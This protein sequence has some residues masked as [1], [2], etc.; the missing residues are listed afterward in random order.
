MMA[1]GSCCYEAVTRH[2]SS[3]QMIHNN[4]Q[5][6]RCFSHPRRDSSSSAV[7]PT[8]S[9]PFPPGLTRLGRS[10]S[11]AS[12]LNRIDHV[13]YCRCRL[14][15]STTAC[16]QGHDRVWSSPVLLMLSSSHHHL[17]RNCSG[18]TRCDSSSCFDD[19]DVV[20]VSVM[21]FWNSNAN[22][23]STTGRE[24]LGPRSW[25]DTTVACGFAA[26]SCRCID[27]PGWLIGP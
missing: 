10:L 17:C 21:H 3:R 23:H 16:V 22:V 7:S 19:P 25:L 6:C 1:G 24:S 12:I 13:Y 4:S 11:A 26:C 5:Y 27:A 8:S 2:G 15:S 9:V 20:S 14:L 18:Q